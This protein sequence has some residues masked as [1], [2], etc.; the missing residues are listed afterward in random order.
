MST[1]DPARTP[2]NANAVPVYQAYMNPILEALRSA[3]GPLLIEELD[4]RVLAKLALGAEVV[5]IP[6]DPAKP[7][8]SE[9]SYRMAWARTYLKKA[10]LLSNTRIGTWALTDEGRTCGEV[11]ARELSAEVVRSGRAENDVEPTESPERI[12]L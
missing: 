7:E 10:G 6:H 8:R 9:V 2:A 12:D 1:P 11:D 3:V 5:A 4:Q